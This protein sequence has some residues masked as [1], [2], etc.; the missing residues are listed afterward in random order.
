M[1][2]YPTTV[3]EGYRTELGSIREKGMAMMSKT[4]PVISS[5]EPR[6]S[7][8]IWRIMKTAGFNPTGSAV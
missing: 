3:R 6:T 7:R 8:L 4:F 5:M 1:M 2:S